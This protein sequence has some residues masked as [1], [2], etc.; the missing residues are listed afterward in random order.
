[1]NKAKVTRSSLSH[2]VDMRVFSRSVIGEEFIERTP[3]STILAVLIPVW[4]KFLLNDR[5]PGPVRRVRQAIPRISFDAD[6][7]D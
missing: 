7:A 3:V 2:L 6:Q 5:K 1:M 4:S